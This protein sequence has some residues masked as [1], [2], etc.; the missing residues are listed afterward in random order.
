MLALAA[1]VAFNG[2]HGTELGLH[3]GSNTGLVIAGG[4]G[5]RGRQEYSVMGDAVNLA[6]RLEGA[7]ERG[8][9]FVGPDSYRLTAPLFELEVVEP[10]RGKG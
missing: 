2:E 9:I 5:S 4:L 7:S 10:I 1:L 8:E 3:F 6:A